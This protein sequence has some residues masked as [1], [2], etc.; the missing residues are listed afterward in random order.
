MYARTKVRGLSASNVH[1]PSAHDSSPLPRVVVAVVEALSCS[2][3]A[4]A[5][6]SGGPLASGRADGDR[7]RC[8][9]FALGGVGV[10]DRPAPTASTG[11]GL[12][13]SLVKHFLPSRAHSSHFV[14]GRLALGSLEIQQ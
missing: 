5:V 10:L 9:V 2:A 7:A 1:C 12:R 3:G 4:S 14:A 6:D 11:D 13:A 8:W